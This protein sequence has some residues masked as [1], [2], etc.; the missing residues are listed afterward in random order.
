VEQTNYPLTLVSGPGERLLLHIAFEQSRFDATAIERMLGHLGTLLAGLS[1]AAPEHRP[2]GLPLLTDAER[3]QALQEWNDTGAAAEGAR[4]HDLFETWAER[5]PAA[6]AVLFQA[7]SYSYGELEAVANRLAHRLQRLGIGPESRVGLCFERSPEALAAMLGVLK[8]G[9][10][11]VPLDSE[12]PRERL[13]GIAADAGIAVLLTHERLA[14]SLTGLA[15]RLV[16]LDAPA[17]RLAEESPERPDCR[18][19]PDNAAYVIY[20]SGSTGAA[21]GVVATHRS[22]VNFARA[23]TRTIGLGPADRLLLFAPLSFDAS[24][25][26]IFSPL[27]SGAAV[28]VH[29]DPRQMASHEILELCERSG[30]T[31]LDLPAALWRQWVEDVTAQGLPLPASL[32]SFLT[33]GESVS[34]S[35]LRTWSELAER[36]LS[37]L[38][39]YGPTEATVTSTVFQTWNQQVPCLAG[40]I[41]P[42]G[43]PLSGTQA[44]VL[45]RAFQP[46]PCGVP[47]ELFLGGAGLARGY[48]GR[49]DLTAD[50]FRPDPFAAEPDGRL[51][52]TGDLAVRRP[53]GDLEF[54]GRTDHQVKLRGFRLEP[55]EVE[56]ALL[57]HPV[58]REAAVV[59]REDR[60]GDP[61]LAAYVVAREGEEAP[62]PAELRASLM[63]KLPTYMVPSVVT[64]LPK[65]P[66]LPSGKLD[67]AALPA[68][69]AVEVGEHISPRTPVEQVLAGIWVEVLGVERVG[70]FDNFFELGGHSLA[71]TRVVARIREELQAELEL[72]RLFEFPTIAGLAENLLADP[73]QRERVEK[74]SELTVQLAQL[75]EEQVE[76]MLAAGQEGDAA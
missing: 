69:V 65:L 40:E 20:T 55:G 56:A 37:F 6:A 52:R 57:R 76:A 16:V 41:V 58:L 12:S 42:I 35:R 73:Q 54:L 7:R 13:A 67:R 36:P 46:A 32:R 70:A 9:G 44:H 33:G 18:A 71:A 38:S 17:E 53:D 68:P 8:A 26:Q 30:I 2:A 62:S 31:V 63:E 45:D 27:A 25:L 51:Y 14:P 34:V 15:D 22:V 1:A 3:L 29:P 11:Y 66:V 24:V 74:T 49:P 60:P 72:R 47:G 39:S 43:R 4:L 23:F 5:A 19:L 64:L 28:V 50:A 59:V 61:Q 10:A 75:S 21:K 48:L